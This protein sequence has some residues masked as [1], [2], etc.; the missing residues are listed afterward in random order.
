[1]SK[2]VEAWAEIDHNGMLDVHRD[3]LVVETWASMTRTRGDISRVV[4]LIEATE[5]RAL[6]KVA[7]A[8]AVELCLREADLRANLTAPED[9]EVLELC[10]RIGFGAV[11]DSAARQWRKRDQ[12]G[13]FVVGSCLG[14]IRPVLA[15][16]EKT[17]KQVK[18]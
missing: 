18:R 3:K 16:Y 12:I 15:A 2:R 11:M 14:L 8:M 17:L 9:P 10:K 13:A 4:H 7:K 6:R 1:M 5:L